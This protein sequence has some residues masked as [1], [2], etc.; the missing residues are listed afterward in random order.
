MSSIFRAFLVLI[1]A[2]AVH[3][4]LA[5]PVIWEAPLNG[6]NF[7][8]EVTDLASTF[9]AIDT[10]PRPDLIVAASARHSDGSMRLVYR[11]GW[12]VAR[13]GVPASW[14][15]AINGPVAGNRVTG[16][17]I[18]SAQLDADAAPEL[19][20]LARE[21]SNPARL[22]FR[23]GWNLRSNGTPRSW[24]DAQSID[25]F[26]SDGGG[27]ALAIGQLDANQRPDLLVGTYERIANGPDRLR[28]RV[29]WNVSFAG[30]PASWSNW[31]SVAGMGESLPAISIALMPLQGDARPELLFA[32]RSTAASPGEFRFRVSDD[33]AT[34]LSPASGRSDIGWPAAGLHP[35][36][37]PSP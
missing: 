19:L 29:G 27:T 21:V 22:T 36:G 31:R 4:A 10:N 13:N 3:P 23:I 17:G 30:T 37:S 18:A 2:A 28:Y 9:A 11:I 25:G 7:A 5:Q 12:N 16:V 1:F 14:S 33:L 24:S 8:A 35:R 32:A 6:P 26:P 34:R 20:I 15:S